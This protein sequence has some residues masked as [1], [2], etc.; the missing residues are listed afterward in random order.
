MIPDASHIM[1]E[2]NPDAYQMALNTFLREQHGELDQKKRG[3]EFSDP[4]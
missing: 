4:L 1:H 3:P 2:D